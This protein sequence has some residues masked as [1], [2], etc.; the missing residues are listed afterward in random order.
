MD[1][2]VV[3][4]KFEFKSSDKSIY[5]IDVVNINT[6]REP[7]LRFAVDVYLNGKV[8]KE[9]GDVTFLPENFFNK[10]EKELRKITEKEFEAI[11][12]SKKK[13][14]IRMSKWTI[15]DFIWIIAIFFVVFGINY[16]L[17]KLSEIISLKTLIMI[18]QGYIAC[19]VALIGGFIKSVFFTDY[20]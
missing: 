15:S 2:V 5:Y 7:D 6:F 19:S 4:D 3:G 14:T 20:K 11:N 16:G 10:Y 12:N 8:V 18:F 1:R 17:V 9:D 13:S